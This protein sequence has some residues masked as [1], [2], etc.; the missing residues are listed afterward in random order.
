MS[1]RTF[2]TT[3]IGDLTFDGFMGS[4]GPYIACREQN[5]RGVALGPTWIRKCHP[6]DGND[7]CGVV[8]NRPTDFLGGWWIIKYNTELRIDIHNFTDEQVDSL[9]NEFG[10]P[11]HQGGD[12]V[13]AF[14]SSAAWEGLREWVR[15]HPRI[16]KE[17]SVRQEYLGDWYARALRN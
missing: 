17:N 15:K 6:F 9:M 12:P 2:Y 8:I 14:Y 5:G 1:N 10:I 13:R 16:A 4:V 11:L 7:Y 3:K